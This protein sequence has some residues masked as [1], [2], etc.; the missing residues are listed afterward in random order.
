MV[1]V[2]GVSMLARVVRAVLEAGAEPV[3]VVGPPREGLPAGV[4]V[5]R[6]E[7]AGGGPVAAAA[8]GVADV[9]ENA[10]YIGVFA[11]D[12]PYL[13]DMAIR[14]LLDHLDE[15]DGALFVDEGGRRQ[16][17]C[18][19]WR[20]GSLRQA[21]ARFGETQGGS[22][23]RLV[24]GLSVGEVRWDGERAPYFDCDTEEDLRR[25]EL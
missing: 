9:G 12:M 1:A 20:A 14:V 8:A 23:R 6:E 11:A 4:R 2:G 24:E 13:S 5:V 3:V 19:V 15:H 17:L 7:P 16:L 18:G 10:A 25:V 22:L 21:I